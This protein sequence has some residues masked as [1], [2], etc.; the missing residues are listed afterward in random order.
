MIVLI[1][2]KYVMLEILHEVKL[3]VKEKIKE[4]IK[5]VKYL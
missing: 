2:D 1:K 4:Q 3:Y 5:L